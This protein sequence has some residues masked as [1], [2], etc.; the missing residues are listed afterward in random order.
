[1]LA[2]T[3]TALTTVLAG[4]DDISE[5]EEPTDSA[6]PTENSPTDTVDS[7]A[8]GTDPGTS[9]PGSGEP[10]KNGSFESDWAA[11]S[12]G[13]YLP[14]DPNRESGRKVASEAGVT[15]RYATD[16]TSACRLFIDGSQD[17]GTLWVQQAVD[18]TDAE[19]LAVDYRVSES[20]N[21]IRN[22][23][24]YTGPVPEEPLTETDFDTEQSLEGHDREGSKTFTDDVAH[25]GP[26]LVAVGFSIIWETGAEAFLDHVR[27]TSDPPEPITPEGT[28][29]SDSPGLSTPEGT[30]E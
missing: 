27:L 3:G 24:V 14:D 6:D 26:G 12:I 20:F 16:G 19:Y 8:P 1:M 21:E 17:D 11:W 4:C 15:T 22:A 5:A 25:D 23:A 30:P 10:L 9:T 13:R 18:L 2:L 7:T 29:E 28:P